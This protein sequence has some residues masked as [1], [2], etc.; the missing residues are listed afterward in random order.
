LI[1]GAVVLAAG[2]SEEVGKYFSQFNGKTMIEGILDT[3]DA[4]SIDERIIVLG[5][6]IDKVVE[7]IRPKLGKFKIALNLTPE[8][9]DVSSFQTGL[10]V[11]QNVD[12]AFLVLGD[13]PIDSAQLVSMVNEMEQNTKALIISPIYNGKK[14]NLILFRKDLFGEIM[15]V[16]S[17][18]TIED[19]INAHADKSVTVEASL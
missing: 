1:V 17:N 3:L 18:Q 10:I 11:I 16:A 19:I 7:V 9:G 4:A 15:S 6:E 5:G 13:A 2:N 8:L 12:A 14:G